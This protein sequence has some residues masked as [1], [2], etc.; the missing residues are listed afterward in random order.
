MNIL[1][2]KM[3]AGAGVM[4]CVRELCHFFC[5]KVLANRTCALH[6]DPSS[7]NTAHDDG[8]SFLLSNL[9]V[10]QNAC[11]YLCLKFQ[12]GALTHSL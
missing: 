3:N 8:V 5:K 7:R 10:Y 4:M 11:Q 6:N 2:H 12:T 9:E 1:Y